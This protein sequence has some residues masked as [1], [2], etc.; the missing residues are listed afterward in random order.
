[1]YWSF[2]VGDG[3]STQ[4]DAWPEILRGSYWSGADFR[5]VSNEPLAVQYCASGKGLSSIS[6]WTGRSHT[7]S[8]KGVAGQV[9]QLLALI[10]L[11]GDG[12]LA[13]GV[14]PKLHAKIRAN[15]FS[16][17][18][19]DQPVT[20]N[21]EGGSHCVMLSFPR[22]WL[23]RSCPCLQQ[24]MHDARPL[25]K[26]V[27]DFF[28]SLTQVIQEHGKGVSG[29]YCEQVFQVLLGMLSTALSSA[30]TFD[31]AIPAG[32]AAK[33]NKQRIV[34]HVL[35]NLLDP[36]LSIASVAEATGLSGRYV[37]KLFAGDKLHL[38][39]WVWNQR[40]QQSHQA[41]QSEAEGGKSITAIA[42]DSGFSDSAHFS[43]AFARCYGM[44]PRDFRKNTL[45]VRV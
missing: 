11:D 37:C 32:T 40:L 4:K 17:F 10:Q 6:E 16:L 13:W 18:P 23:D 12:T 3:S 1:M 2:V 28:L 41:L 25:D 36:S 22:D 8:L 19:M 44:S 34:S 38:M 35:N 33:R 14:S 45:Q 43:R 30:S 39:Q 31:I 24:H 27:S 9:D 15:E 26:S 42:Y 5:T 21:S 20:F 7:L 29:K